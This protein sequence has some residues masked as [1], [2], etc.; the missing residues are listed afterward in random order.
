MAD[1]PPTHQYLPAIVLSDEDEPEL[2]YIPI[3]EMEPSWPPNERQYP[4]AVEE[5]G[6]DEEE[7]ELEDKIE[8]Y[9]DWYDEI[10]ESS[11][12]VEVPCCI[13]RIPTLTTTKEHPDRA[14]S[15]QTDQI[16]DPANFDPRRRQINA[17]ELAGSTDRNIPTER[18]GNT[19]P[20]GLKNDQRVNRHLIL[21]YGNKGADF[22]GGW[23]TDKGETKSDS[24]RY[25]SLSIGRSI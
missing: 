5:V 3:Q 17:K 16:S 25:E 9:R 2:E 12:K 7:V 8:E 22:I 20:A 21:S 10:E 19:Q 4:S 6:E 23:E 14:G 15:D 18:K 24:A 11:D 13:V 1:D